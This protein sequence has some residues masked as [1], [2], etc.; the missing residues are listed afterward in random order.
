MNQNGMRKKPSVVLFHIMTKRPA[1]RVGRAQQK[2]SEGAPLDS[3][4]D[5]IF[6]HQGLL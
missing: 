2:E 3:R 6:C 1:K 5:L 4:R